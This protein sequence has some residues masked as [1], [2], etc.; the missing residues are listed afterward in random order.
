METQ[1]Y[2]FNDQNQLNELDELRQ[3]ITAI[4]NKVDLE[5]RLN[6]ALVKKTIQGKMQG[7]H[8]SIYTYIISC[9]VFVPFL[10]WYMVYAHMSWPFIIF[11]SLMFLGSFTAEY[12]INRMNVQHMTD[13]LVETA[14][15]LH[16]MKNNRKKQLTVGFCVLAVWS[17]WYLYEMYKYMSNMVDVQSKPSFMFGLIIACII[18]LLI[19]GAIGLTFYRKM[20]RANDEMINQI[21]E[22]TREQ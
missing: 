13:D 22:L 3:Q 4:K 7:L 11:T 20:Q 18:G 5:G 1:N 6:E 12:L 2:T 19:G 15:K 14:R 10:I 8:R 16:Q 9:A 21:N 17:P